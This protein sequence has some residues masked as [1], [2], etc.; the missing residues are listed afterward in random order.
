MKRHLSLA[1]WLLLTLSG[2]LHAADAPFSPEDD[3]GTAA[4]PPAAVNPPPAR[5]A[6]QG[7]QTGAPGNTAPPTRRGAPGSPGALPLPNDGQSRPADSAGA[8]SATP[9]TASPLLQEAQTLD[10]PLTPE[11]IRTLRKGMQKT[12]RALKAPVTSVVP[13][14]SSQTVNLAPGASLPLLRL[15][16]DNIS[17]VTFQDSTGAPWPLA[18]PPLNANNTLFSVKYIPDSAVMSVLPLT[19]WATGNLTVYL[20]GLAVPVVIN[21]TSGDPDSDARAREVDSRL[22]LRIPRR[23][24]QAAA[25]AT[26][27][28]RIALHDATLQAFLDGMP[29]DTAKRLKVTGG[30][31]FLVVWQV[32]DDLYVRARDELRDEFVQTLSSADGTHL[33]KLPVTPLLT[34]SV[35]GRTVS[36]FPELE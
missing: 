28:S 1:G 25:G 9:A 33:W 23:G 3:N 4:A 21:L 16:P 26:P 2:V 32:G 15:A 36:A 19:A 27:Q 24:P 18:A 6:G 35:N 17:N 7:S 11:E 29:P 31:D 34:F 5:P 10:T 8:D 20:K 12:D 22:D 13:R 14:I 30:P